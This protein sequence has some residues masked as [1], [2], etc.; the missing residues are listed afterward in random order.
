MT[1]GRGAEFAE[2]YVNHHRYATNG[3]HFGIDDKVRT[4]HSPLA[5]F[6]DVICNPVYKY[7]IE[8][9]VGNPPL[10]TTIP[11]I[12]DAASRNRKKWD[13][14]VPNE[15]LGN[16][17]VFTRHPRGCG[18][19]ID[20]DGCDK[21]RAP[22]YYDSSLWQWA[23]VTSSHDPDVPPGWHR[24][25]HLK[26]FPD[27]SCAGNADQKCNAHVNIVYETYK[28]DAAVASAYEEAAD[29]SSNQLGVD[30]SALQAQK[31][32]DEAKL[33]A[34]RAAQKAAQKAAQNQG[35]GVL[36]AVFSSFG[37][38]LE[39]QELAQLV[40]LLD[41]AEAENPAHGRQLFL[42]ALA[43]V[44]TGGGNVDVSALVGSSGVQLVEHPG[45]LRRASWLLLLLLLIRRRQRGCRSCLR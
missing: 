32:E 43:D 36:G 27:R 4:L 45:H 17:D 21:S 41:Q 29:A 37:R 34:Q 33:A 24:L 38:R 8:D 12:T 2:D 6:R 35:N 15:L 23:Y 18:M 1:S 19:G 25:L 11:E 26:A 30:M 44:V 16:V 28:E 31:A 39:E 14:Y 22:S 20:V 10:V 5:L 3:R 9:A 42:D 13:M 7:R 40:P